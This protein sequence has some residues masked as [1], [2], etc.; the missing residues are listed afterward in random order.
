MLAWAVVRQGAPLE[1]V[2]LATPVPSGTEVMVEV[3]YCGLCHSDLHMWE[4]TR[5]MGRRGI[6]RRVL[7]GPTAF[8]HEIVGRV[9]ALG[10]EAEG[11]A[12]GERRIVYPWL[13]CGRCED[14]R[15][16]NDH[17]CAVESRILGSRQ[18]GGF[19]Q[20]V[21]VPHPRYLVDPGSLDP[22][23]AATYACSGLTVLSAIRKLLPL[24][25]DSPVVVIGT[26]GVGL[27]AIAML[28]ALGH[29]AIVAV[30]SSAAKRAVALEAGATAFVHTEG[31]G[32]A[33]AIID[34]AGGK[35]D[36][37]L[38]LVSNTATSAAAF[39]CLRKR[40]KMV[41]VGLFG[42][43]LVV[44][45]SLLIN[46]AITIQGSV[47]GS[48]Q[49]LHDVVALAR[50]G[51]LAPTRISQLPMDEANAALQRLLQGQVEGRLVLRR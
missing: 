26:G 2:E 48:L 13:G 32:A 43:E 24:P 42:G 49:N 17:L 27:Q 23:L 22:A 12:S 14:C 10:P 37:V 5:D 19:A 25:P 38:D 8:G 6:V 40:G 7:H 46:E 41:Q 34:A 21:V 4:G 31:E 29:R 50:S 51:R 30:D 15:S 47:V 9:A 33:A 20:F 28:R 44:P 1:C 3:E 39:D 11:I 36:A 18:Q 45:L 16:G 35:V